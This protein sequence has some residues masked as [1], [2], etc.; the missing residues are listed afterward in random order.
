M[1]YVMD[2][3]EGRIFW[4]GRLPDLSS[5]ERSGIYDSMNNALAA[6]HR[7]DPAVVGPRSTPRV[8]RP[9]ATA[10]E[11]R[12]GPSISNGMRN[13]RVPAPLGSARVR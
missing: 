12:N 3:V 4:D 10:V 1:F 6:L 13:R 8:S 7:V 2:Y 5:E 11:P 9:A